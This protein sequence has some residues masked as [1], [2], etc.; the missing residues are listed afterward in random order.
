[1][2]EAELLE[3]IASAERLKAAASARQAKDSVRLAALVAARRAQEEECRGGAAESVGRPRDPSFDVGARIALARQESPSKGGQLLGLAR[4]LVREMPHTL[5]ALAAGRINEWRATLVARETAC[6]SLEDRV[7]V[8]EALVP[9]YARQ[10]AGDRELVAEAKRAAQRLDPAAAVKR[11]RKA[12]NERRVSVRPAPDSMAY[13]TCLL[14]AAQAIA[15]YKALAAHADG[16]RAAGTTTTDADG[17][18]AA[19]P[20]VPRT[21]DQVMADTLVERLTGQAKASDLRLEV[22]LLIAD[23]AL[24]GGSAEPAVLPGYGVIPAQVARDLVAGSEQ[25]FALRRLYAAPATGA[26]VAMES[27]A[28]IFPEP[29]KRLIA[30]RDR[31]CR[32]PWCDAP[33][34]QY[35]HVVPAARGGPT[36]AANG[37]GLCERCNQTK[38]AP[39]W[40]EATVPATRHTIEVRTPTGEVYRSTAPPLPGTREILYHRV[41]F[42][43]GE[44]VFHTAA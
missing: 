4:A 26:L 16:L 9:I 12:A 32:G 14:P 3:R 8:D 43:G 33:L 19:G 5:N 6:L 22:Q 30:A 7:R 44:Y 2:D 27:R 40:A 34:R 17:A 35:D 18:A 31:T 15:A 21:R 36:T 29:L 23:S 28:R 42:D 20:G 11:A 1:M 38:E 25:D 37:Q 13:L 41:T 10:G 24:L 39:G